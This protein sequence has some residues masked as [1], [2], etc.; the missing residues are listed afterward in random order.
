MLCDGVTDLMADID[1]DLR[2][3]SRSVT[4]EAEEAI[5]AGDPGPRWT[6]LSDWL[7]ER[8]ATAVA[9][10]FVWAEQRSE[11]LAAQVVD[12]FARDGGAILPDLS[13]DSA[14]EALG[15]VVELPEI[16]SGYLK[17]RE[18]LLIGVR[19]SYTGVLM[20]GLVTSLAGMALINPISVAAGVL[21]GRKAWNDDKA[22]RL[23]RRQSEAKAVVR[24][25]LDEVVFQVGK[26]LKD[27]LRQ[28]QRTLRDV[29]GEAVEEMS[30]SVGEALQAAQ[31]S[32]R[33]ATQER[34]ARIR[35][36]KQRLVQIERL[37][38]DVR[39]LPRVR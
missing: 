17:V 37:S 20:T 35:T 38:A 14:S 34:D 5:D 1:Y 22:Q 16:D 18:R 33:D 30:N 26:Q 10:C 19:G 6:Q 28:V 39:R 31:R 7:D 21:L 8:V 15:A 2:D 36:L 11:F 24:R 12:Q 32:S 3:R 25:H 23:Q 9:D 4:R 27:R 13:M 29:L